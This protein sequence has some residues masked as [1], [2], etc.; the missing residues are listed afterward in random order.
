MKSEGKQQILKLCRKY[1]D[2]FH[3]ENQLWTIINKIK[4][5]INTKYEIPVF[6][7][8]YRYPFVCKPEVDKQIKSMLEQGIIRLSNSPWSSPI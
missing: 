8:S 5:S 7:K 3:Y 2:S 6:T 4:H 1:S